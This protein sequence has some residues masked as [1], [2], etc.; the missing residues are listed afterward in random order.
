MGGASLYVWLPL[1]CLIVL[2]ALFALGWGLSFVGRKREPRG[3][4]TSHPQKPRARGK[5]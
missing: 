4:V 2:G 3:R 5:P 1:L